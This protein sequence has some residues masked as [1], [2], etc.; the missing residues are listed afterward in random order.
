MAGTALEWG[1]TYRLQ[2]TADPAELLA[3]AADL[4]AADPVVTT[5]VSTVTERAVREDVEG[6]PRP[7]HPRWWV[8]VHDADDR[9]V[10]VAMRTAPFA[11]Y[12][13]FVLPMPDDAARA[14]A[15]ALVARDEDVTGVNGALPAVEVIAET[16]AEHAGGGSTEVHTHMR[17]H[18]LDDLVE[19]APPSGRMRVATPDD[20]ALCLAWFQVFD[21]EASAQAGRPHGGHGGEHVEL[22]QIK[23]KIERR[24][25]W[26]WE[27]DA[28]EIAHLTAHNPPSFGVAR[29]GPVYTPG[30]QRGRGYAS[31]AVAAVSRMLREAGA[32]VCLFTDQANATSNKIY[33]AIGFVPVVDMAN[34]LVTRPGSA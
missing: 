20:A 27:D 29:I 22:E 12:P 23:G 21:D 3:A 10:G 33:A 30:T 15:E 13:V 34:L 4:L 14:V 24:E 1:M 6:K 16:L 2:F 7:D 9:V 19:P 8:S 32:E 18:V 28:G 26:L 17:L 25:I 11:P 31:A 5:V